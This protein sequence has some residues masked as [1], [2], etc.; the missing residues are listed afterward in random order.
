MLLERLVSSDILVSNLGIRDHAQIIGHDA[1]LCRAIFEKHDHT[2]HVCGVKTLA[3]LEIDHTAG[4]SKSAK[5]GMKPIC[6]FCHDL[7]HPL[8]AASR[9]RLVP[10]WGPDLN[11]TDLIR[12]SWA[13]VTWRDVHRSE[14]LEVRSDLITRKD[15]IEEYIGWSDINIALSD[16]ETPHEAEVL[17]EAAFAAVDAIGAELAKPALRKLDQVVRFIPHEVLRDTD[18]KA[19]QLSSR[20]S[21]WSIGGFRKISKVVATDLLQRN[22]PASLQA[23]TEESQDDE[24]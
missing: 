17:F 5:K 15:M 10:I 19:F 18:D 6:Q 12:L 9:G 20:L 8:W 16:T 13:L 3:G 7:K 21:T 1:D 4:H 22:D 11:Q 14:Y 24:D 23:M 2:C